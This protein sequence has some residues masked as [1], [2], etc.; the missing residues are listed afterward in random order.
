MGKGWEFVGCGKDGGPR[1]FQ[2]GVYFDGEM[3]VAKC[4]DYCAKEGYS[5]AGLEYASQ[6]Y[7]DV[8]YQVPDR[9]LS[10]YRACDDGACNNN[11]FL[12]NGTGSNNRPRDLQSRSEMILPDRSFA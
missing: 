10:I 7:C 12:V 8:D 5:Y 6:C 9:A 4:M 3:T 2:G 11:M 1:T